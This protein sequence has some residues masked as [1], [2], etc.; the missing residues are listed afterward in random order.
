MATS[1]RH[2][3]IYRCVSTPASRGGYSPAKKMMFSR[4]VCPQK[5]SVSPQCIPF[6]P[7]NK[8]L[9]PLHSWKLTPLTTLTF[10]IC[11]LKMEVDYFKYFNYFKYFKYFKVSLFYVCMG[12]YMKNLKMSITNEGNI[13]FQRRI[14]HIHCQSDLYV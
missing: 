5:N 14:V 1:H 3:H 6:W 13:H 4:R 12:K 11:G 9:Y 8:S 2:T 10:H 7:A